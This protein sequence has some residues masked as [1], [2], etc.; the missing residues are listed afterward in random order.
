MNTNEPN[1]P[2]SRRT[3]I[4][5]GTAA[6]V[7]AAALSA[8]GA[9]SPRTSSSATPADPATTPANPRPWGFGGFALDPLPWKEDALAPVISAQTISFHYG[10]HHK[11]YVDN[12]NKLVDGKPYASQSLEDVMRASAKVEADTG[13]FNNAAQIW[14]HSFYWKSLAPNAKAPEGKLLERL[15]ADFGG[16]DECK[17]ALLDAAKGQFGSGWAWL[18]LDGQ[19]LKVVKTGN[20]DNPMLRGAKPLL[21]IDVWEH[22]YYLDYQN[23]RPDYVQAVMDKLLNWEHA[24]S[25]L[26]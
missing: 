23:R 19:K 18:V 20:A 4:V 16:V 10:K 24:A 9:T 12:L 21:V 2:I 22:A 8:R 5:A 15:K 11:S 6:V 26:G 17:K 14:N 1:S 25:Q 7:G 3:V 13:V